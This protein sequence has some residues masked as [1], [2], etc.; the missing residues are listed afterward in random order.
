MARFLTSKTFII[1]KQKGINTRF[2]FSNAEIPKRQIKFNNNTFKT[3]K[4]VGFSI[5]KLVIISSIPDKELSDKIKQDIIK[6]KPIILS[7]Y[8]N[9]L[10]V[11]LL[12][13]IIKNKTIN[14][15]QERKIGAKLLKPKKCP[16]SCPDKNPAPNIQPHIKKTVKKISL[17]FFIKIFM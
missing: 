11:N 3:I 2:I 16:N 14:I 17:I 8:I 5:V 9:F 7:L 4:T 1:I 12:E 6:N 15:A 10:H 13:K